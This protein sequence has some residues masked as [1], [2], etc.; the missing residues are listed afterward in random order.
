MMSQINPQHHQVCWRRNWANPFESLW[1]LL[2]KFAFLNA[3]SAKDIRDLLGRE[4]H[5][6]SFTHWK[7]ARRSDLR[8]LEGIDIQL[9]SQTLKI[10]EESL[11]QSTLV[12]FM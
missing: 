4:K 12:P 8:L 9:L 7:R 1:S 6:W 11:L 5:K 2:R 3:A 10:D